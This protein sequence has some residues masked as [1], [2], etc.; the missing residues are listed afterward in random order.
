MYLPFTKRKKGAAVFV[1]KLLY[2]NRS[3]DARDL[4]FL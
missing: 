3:Y 1:K 4:P 2:L